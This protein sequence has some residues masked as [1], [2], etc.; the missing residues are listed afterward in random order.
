MMTESI[1]IEEVVLCLDL[2]KGYIRKQIVWFWWAI[3]LDFSLWCKTDW[4]LVVEK[5][6]FPSD[7]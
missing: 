7:R 5:L 6:L 2:H 3:A 1:F 4:F